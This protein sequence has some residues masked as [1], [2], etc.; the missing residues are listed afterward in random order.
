MENWK[1]RGGRSEIRKNNKGEYFSNERTFPYILITKTSEKKIKFLKR[2]HK[3]LIIFLLLILSHGVTHSYTRPDLR[4][5]AW[6][7][8]Y[9]YIRSV[10]VGLHL[11]FFVTS[12]FYW[13][14]RN[15]SNC[16]PHIDRVQSGLFNLGK[17]LF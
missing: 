2:L 11:F 16:R 7:T 3:V 9:I 13:L 17:W 5:L 12:E 8:V 14:F 15:S 6:W 1:R 4:Y 10:P